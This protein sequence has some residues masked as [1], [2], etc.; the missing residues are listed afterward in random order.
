M[1]FPIIPIASIIAI[2][3]GVGSLTWYSS[4]S[5]EEKE[6]A[7]SKANV[8][9]KKEFGKALDEL[10]KEEFELVIDAIESD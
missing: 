2:L 4:L 6:D 3:G 9:A 1:V 10:K 5:A 7:D 8:Y